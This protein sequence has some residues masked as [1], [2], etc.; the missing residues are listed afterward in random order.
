MVFVRNDGSTG[1]AKIINLIHQCELRKA[2]SS[3]VLK[4]EC[5]FLL[6]PE[7]NLGKIKQKRQNCFKTVTIKI[8]I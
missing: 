8:I 1:N 2:K 4:F 3:K 7:S 5:Y 6:A